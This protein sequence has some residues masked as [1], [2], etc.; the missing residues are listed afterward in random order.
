MSTRVSI[1]T[2][3]LQHANTRTFIIYTW[4]THFRSRIY[5][6]AFHRSD[7]H[8]LLID[9]PAK[10]ITRCVTY[11]CSFFFTFWKDNFSDKRVKSYTVSEGSQDYIFRR[12]I[13]IPWHR[14]RGLSRFREICQNSII[15]SIYLTDMYNID[16]KSHAKLFYP[17]LSKFLRHTVQ[18][19]HTHVYVVRKDCRVNGSH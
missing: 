13:S 5:P 7:K 3:F 14:D 9:V 2:C 8:L 11:S 12:A 4:L 15:E 18:R 10:D 1:S 17:S 16:T 6:G 19:S